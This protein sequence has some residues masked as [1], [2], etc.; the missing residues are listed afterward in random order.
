M[1]PTLEGGPE[2]ARSFSSANLAIQATDLR[3]AYG[4]L[5]AV[6]GIALEVHEGEIFGL[7]GPDGAGK[8][9]TF[10][11]LAGVMEA[12]SGTVEVFGATR[13]RGPLDCR[14][15]DAVL[16]PLSRSQRGGEHPLHRR[17]AACAPA[18]NYRTRR[19]LSAHV[20][21]GPLHRAA[22]RAAQRRHE[23][24][25]RRSPARWWRSRA[26][27]C[28]TSPP[29][30]SIPYRAA[31]SG[32]RWRTWRPMASPSWWPRPIWTKPSAA[33]PWRSCISARS[34]RPARRRELRES[35]GMRR[36]E[37]HTAN[38]AEAEDKL[39]AAE[40]GVISDVQRFGDRLDVM[41]RD[42]EAGR[43]AVDETLGKGRRGGGAISASPIPRSRTPSSPRCAPWA[44]NCTRRPF[45]AAIRTAIWPEK[46]PSA[47]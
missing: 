17:P 7:I 12:T 43:A 34:T 19:P 18:G 21:H 42:P 25:A 33:I 22:G 9:T 28:S 44:R 35:L 40:G 2:S 30:A 13:A 26:C 23:A 37:V 46:W 5:E 39:T 11:I 36:L 14:L 24:E 45:P 47:R 1:T 31:N 16:Q 6:R 29:P 4:T 41:V 20:R 32:T 15:S 10:Q 3:K 8:T 38:L 27:C